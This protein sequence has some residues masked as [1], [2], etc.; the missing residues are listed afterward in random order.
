[1]LDAKAGWDEADP[2]ARSRRRTA[3]PGARQSS[4]TRTS[5]A[6][7]VHSH[8]YLAMEQ[9]LEVHSSGRF[10]L[11]IIDTPPSRNA[12]HLLDAPGRMKE[13]FESR[14]LKLARGA[15]PLAAVHRGIEALLPGG[16][17][18]ARRRLPA[19]HR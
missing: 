17:S 18:G 14:L 15:L 3:R 19:R 16:R 12:L 2:A 5:P 4:S 13:F 8:D 10:D 11:V 9:L 1:M 7:F 6:R